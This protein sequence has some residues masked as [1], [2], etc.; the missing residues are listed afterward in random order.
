MSPGSPRGSISG[1]CSC[2]SSTR[3]YNSSAVPESRGQVG[4]VRHRMLG[5][6]SVP[7]RGAERG[8]PEIERLSEALPRT[9]IVAHV[10]LQAAEI[11]QGRKPTWIGFLV[12]RGQHPSILFLAIGIATAQVQKEAEIL[13]TVERIAMFFGSDSSPRAA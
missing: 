8:P 1:F 6:H 11:V 4:E 7:V 12:V 13:S 3:A 9:L 5:C 10:L 2:A